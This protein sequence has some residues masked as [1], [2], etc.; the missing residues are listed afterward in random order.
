MRKVFVAI[1][2]IF[3]LVAFTSFQGLTAPKGQGPKDKPLVG[4]VIAYDANDQYLGILLGTVGQYD[5]IFISDPI[6]YPVYID[7]ESGEVVKRVVYFVSDD[8]TGT[9][10]SHLCSSCSS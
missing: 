1:M 2:V 8:C 4:S 9:P 7:K 3:V 6:N 5:S 10:S